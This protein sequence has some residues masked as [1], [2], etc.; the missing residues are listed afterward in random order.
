VARF[1][2]RPDRVVAALRAAWPWGPTV[3]GAVA[4]SVV[5]FPAA[6]AI[7]DDEGRLSYASLDRR[8]QRLAVGL[9]DEGVAPGTRLGVLCWNH[10][11]FVEALVAGARIGADL[12]FLNTGFAR[13]QLADVVASERV[14]VMVVDDDLRPLT[15]G[16]GARLVLDETDRRALV[17]GSRP[18]RASA[19]VTPP[20]QPGNLIILTSGTTGRPKG[21]RRGGNSGLAGIAGMLARIPVRA[22]DTVVVSAPAFHA[23]GLSQTVVGL[24]VGATLVL[25]RRFDPGA[26]VADWAE[27]RARVAV[28]VPFMLSRILELGEEQLSSYDTSA[29][30]VVA[31]SGSVLGRRLVGDVTRRFGPV[32]YNVYGS[33]EVAAATVARPRDLADEPLT[34]GRPVPGVEVRILDDLGHPLGTGRT[35]RIFVGSALHF[36]G[37]TTGGAPQARDGLLSTG[38]LGHLD[39]RGMLFVDGREDDMIVSGGENVFPAEVEELLRRHPAIAD[40]AVV[41]QDDERFGQSLSAHVVVRPGVTLHAEEVRSWVR[42][43]LARHKVPRRVVFID[44]L[45]RGPAGKVQRDRL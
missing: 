30:R 8:C 34:V 3:S 28:V 33:T 4:A 14:E 40:V 35:G 1:P 13:P 10:R 44:E 12:V 25:R 27:Q 2:E 41:G 11:G 22:R 26:T 38:D 23:W 31:S 37:Y 16:V 15:D 6:D 5:R 17:D 24:S 7:I 43:R 21:A 29:L 9:R 20:K 19:D 32:L 42:D 18:A 45:P 39:R 36:E